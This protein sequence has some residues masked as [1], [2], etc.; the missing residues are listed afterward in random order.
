MDGNKTER[1]LTGHDVFQ[2]SLARIEWAFETFSSVCISFS[3]GKDSTVLFHL[4]AQVARRRKRRFYV[5]FIDWEAQYAVTIAHVMHM[6]VLYADVTEQFFWVALPLTTVNGVSQ[7]QPEWIA[8]EQG[9]E[10]VRQP[11]AEAITDP[12]YFP[13]YYTAMTF[14]EFVTEFAGWLAHGKCLINMIGV[15][16]D[17]S[18][19]RYVGLVSARKRRYASDIPWTTALMKGAGYTGY[20]LYDWKVRDIWLYHY[21]TGAAS[22]GLYDL[23]YRAGLPLRAMRICEPFGPEQRQ[24]L[25]LFHVLEPETWGRVCCRVAGAHSGAIYASES[26]AFYALRKTIEKPENHTWRSYA[27][28]LLDSMPVDTAEHYR[29]K[30]ARYVK[31]YRTRGFPDDIPDQQENDTGWKDIPS[32]RRICKALIKNDYW[33]RM[34]SFSP[35]K[36]RFYEQYKKR[37]QNKRKAWGIL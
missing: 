6:K 19:N 10:W 16:S 31:W 26:G 30:I 8:W 20:P 13:F 34:L 15:R 4:T 32:W 21:R 35:T 14:E 1:I 17:E 28:F 29:N 22:N 27:L 5:L 12:A 18:L 36:A 7:Y 2:E 11:P 33:C 9:H 23:M 25:W 3:G 37:M 24:G